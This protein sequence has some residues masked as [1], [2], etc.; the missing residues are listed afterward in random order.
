MPALSRHWIVAGLLYGVVLWI[1]MY[2]IVMPL[3]WDGYQHAE[4]A[5]GDRPAAV[6]ALHARRPADRVVRRA[7]RRRPTK[8]QL[9]SSNDFA[10]PPHGAQLR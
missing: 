4:R 5:G 2:W 8:F 3:R 1:V 10:P 7:A 6:L 9:K